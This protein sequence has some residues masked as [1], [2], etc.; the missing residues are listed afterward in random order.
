MSAVVEDATTELLAGLSPLRRPERMEARRAAIAAAVERREL[1]A[2]AGD[3]PELREG[4]LEACRQDPVTFINDWCWTHDPRNAGTPLPTTVPFDL[5]PKQEELVRWFQERARTGSRGV[6]E[7]CRAMGATWVACGY[8][9]HQWLFVPGWTGAFGSRKL[10]LVDSL[11]DLD[12]IIEKIRFMLRRLPEWMRPRLRAAD[13]ARCQLRNPETGAIITG[14]AGDNMGR[15]G[16]ATFYFLDEFAHVEHQEAVDNAVSDNADCIIMAST[17]NGADNHFYATRHSGRAS[18]FT[19]RWSDHPEKDAAWYAWQKATRDARSLAQEVDIDYKASVLQI[20]HDE[21]WPEYAARELPKVGRRL[22]TLDSSYKK[23][24]NNSPSC[25]ITVLEAADAVYVLDFWCERVEY[26]ELKALVYDKCRAWRPR[27]L[28][29]E[30]KASGQSL[31]QEME[32]ANEHAAEEDRLPVRRIGVD[33]DK[34][35][36]AQSITPIVKA[37]LVRLPAGAPWLADWRRIF[38]N[39]NE[40]AKIKDPVDALSQLLREI[41]FVPR[42]GAAAGRPADPLVT[43]KDDPRWD[44]QDEGGAESPMGWS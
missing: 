16:R 17:P 8:A 19:L 3:H 43:G 21:W 24:E 11:G 20:F 36:R 10:E 33:T 29:I 40:T 42:T 25:L 35:A 6:I 23:G 41:K 2:A 28:Y 31:I 18:V 39:F 38:S 9:L 44:E 7:K 32:R 37:G 1:I 22:Q 14:E 4:I 30:D 26:P 15:G 13:D 27:T 34:I 12:S 5:F